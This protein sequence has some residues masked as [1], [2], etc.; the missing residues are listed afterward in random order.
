MPDFYQILVYN[1]VKNA[2]SLLIGIIE[3]YILQGGHKKESKVSADKAN[4]QIWKS[5]LSKVLFSCNKC[6]MKHV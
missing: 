1:K 3:P 6:R 5:K 2:E 4:D